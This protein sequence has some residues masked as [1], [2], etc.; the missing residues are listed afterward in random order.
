MRCHEHRPEVG[1]LEDA[2]IQDG[3]FALAGEGLN[4]G[5]DGRSPVPS[6][7]VV[8]DISGEPYIDLEK[9]AMAVLSRERQEPG[10]EQRRGACLEH[11]LD[12][13][14]R[15]P[16]GVRA[17]LSRGASCSPRLGRRV[18]CSSASPNRRSPGCGR[19]SCAALARGD[20]G[21]HAPRARTPA[22]AQTSATANH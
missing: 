4:V 16:H 2:K 20:V 9:E 13:R 1:S 15:V 22:K 7:Y 5:R 6:D 21:I 8:V 3:K 19:Q 12:P 18:P 17:V 14:G 11:G 10:D